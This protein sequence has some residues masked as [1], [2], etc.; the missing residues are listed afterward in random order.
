MNKVNR[1]VA[2]KTRQVNNVLDFLIENTK[3]TIA[4]ND[5]DPV[6][7]RINARKNSNIL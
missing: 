2:Y 1:H 3:T 6:V 7:I 5:D 4:F